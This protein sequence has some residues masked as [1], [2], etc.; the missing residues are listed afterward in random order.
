[1][2]AGMN[3]PE[4]GEADLIS[5]VEDILEMKKLRDWANSPPTSKKVEIKIL[6]MLYKNIINLRL[7]IIG[8]NKKLFELE[9]KLDSNKN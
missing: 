4:Q 3:S 9:R 7:D 8:V 6:D 1:M 2:T 5:E